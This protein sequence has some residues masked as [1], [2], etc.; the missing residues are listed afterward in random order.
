MLCR[1]K[2]WIKD[3][4]IAVKTVFSRNKILCIAIAVCAA[5]GIILAYS[6]AKSA[7][8]GADG[9][10]VIKKLSCG[11][12]NFLLFYFLLLSVTSAMYFIAVLMAFNC[13]AIFINLPIVFF[14]VKCFFKKAFITCIV[15]GF[16]GILTLLLL[17]LPLLAINLLIYTVFLCELYYSVCYGLSWKRVTP[18]KCNKTAIG[19]L[20]KIFV[21]LSILFNLIYT[22]VILI[23]LVIIY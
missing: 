13:L 17:Y 3:R 6:G 7:S 20:L 8:D 16:S 11:E 21:P 18:L 23:I 2:M 10:N 15:D 14:V 12:F 22:A 19:K 9:G 5:L 4:V 1:I